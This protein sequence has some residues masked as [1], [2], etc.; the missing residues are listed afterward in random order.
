MPHNAEQHA[1]RSDSV[2]LQRQQSS[3][4]VSTS[5][6]PYQIARSWPDIH[7]LSVEAHSNKPAPQTSVVGHAT[8]RSCGYSLKASSSQG[9]PVPSRAAQAFTARGRHAKADTYHSSDPR[10]AQGVRDV[11]GK[12]KRTP[13]SQLAS[14]LL[15]AQGPRAS[16]T[17]MLHSCDAQRANGSSALADIPGSRIANAEMPETS[18]TGGS[19]DMPESGRSGNGAMKVVE[20]RADP[21]LAQKLLERLGLNAEQMAAATSDIECAKMILAGS[22]AWAMSENHARCS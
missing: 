7:R 4:N 18:S 11:S 12:Q 3:R 5:G 20:D 9:R 22:Y 8:S 17:N 21:E 19:A 15:A 13:I 10:D 2:T 16:S 1:S 14:A 6:R